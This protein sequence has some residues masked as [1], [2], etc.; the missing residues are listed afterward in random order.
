MSKSIWITKETLSKT[1][2]CT[3]LSWQ[4]LITISR[5]D[6]L[7]KNFGMKIMAVIQNAA[8]LLLATRHLTGEP[9]FLSFYKIDTQKN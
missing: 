3:Q 8:Q 5:I 2:N 4:L 6:V 9:Y 1:E 7:K